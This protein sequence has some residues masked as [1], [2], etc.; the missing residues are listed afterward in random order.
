MYVVNKLNH[1]ELMTFKT[2]YSYERT[3]KHLD[4]CLFIDDRIVWGGEWVRGDEK[5]TNKHTNTQTTCDRVVATQ[6]TRSNKS[7]TA[8]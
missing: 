2:H 6:N 3:T 4:V 7:C 5:Q 8:R 1:T